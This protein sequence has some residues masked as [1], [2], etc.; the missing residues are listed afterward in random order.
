MAQTTTLSS[1]GVSTGIG[2]NPVSKT[3]VIQ[4]TNTSTMAMDVVIQATLDDFQGS[5]TPTWTNISTVHYTS[6][7]LFSSNQAD[8]VFVT[9]LSPIAGLRISSTTY[10]SGTL[11][12]KCLQAVTA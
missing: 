5:A 9:L 6:A 11:T 8:G 2:L 4:L 3:T 10:S 12:L 7:T 1:A